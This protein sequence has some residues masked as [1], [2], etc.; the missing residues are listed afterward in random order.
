MKINIAGLMLCTFLVGCGGEAPFGQDATD[1]DSGSDGGDG[2]IVSDRV[3]PPGTVSPK[4]NDSIFRK[5]PK[6][7]DSGDGFA[8]GIRYI[9]ENDTFYVDNLPFDGS[10]DTPYVRGVAVGSLGDYAV[11]EAVDQYPD[12]Q[13]AAPI[14]QFT[15]RAIYG[16]SRTGNTE[17]A[18][19]RTG[20]YVQ[21]GFGGFV[22]QRNGSVQMPTS[23]QGLYN[24]KGAGLRDYNSTG[25]LEYTTSSVQIVIDFD[26]F[27]AE[28]G[29]YEG[30]VDGFVFDRRVFDLSGNEITGDIAER[31]GEANNADLGG[32]LPTIRFF[33]TQDSLDA[34]GELT[35]EVFSTF[36]SLAGQ[37]VNYEE[38]KYYGVLAGDNGEELV[39]VIVAETGIDPASPDG[40]RDTT[41]FTIY[42]EARE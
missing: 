25:L 42:R 24:G 6:D 32:R 8:E 9:A 23:G 18:I 15:H 29:R 28:T 7:G 14:N 33:I 38:G 10:D 5:E 19:V 35:G 40:V 1:P 17:F 27:N 41:G 26:D 30:A 20:A 31:I 22:Y 21:Y 36:G 37:A 34:N 13:T 11:Y 16:V 12:T 39:G 2:G 4:P 3:V